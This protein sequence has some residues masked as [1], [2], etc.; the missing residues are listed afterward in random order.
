MTNPLIH[1]ALSGIDV[2]QNKLNASIHN[3]TNGTTEGYKSIDVIS[4]D[5]G[6]RTQRSAGSPLDQN[7]NSPT[8]IQ[9][10]TGTKVIATERNF[11]A[12]PTKL[13]GDEMHVAISGQGFFQVERAG[14]FAYTRAGRLQ[15]KD[16]LLT[17]ESGL[18]LDPPITIPDNL[19]ELIISGDGTITAKIRGEEDLVE[20]GQLV[21]FNF[22]NPN[23]LKAIGDNLYLETSASGGA[24]EMDAGD[25]MSDVIKHKCL[26]ESNVNSFAELIKIMPI[27]DLIK[28]ISNAIK[29]CEET[30]KYIIEH[31]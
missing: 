1:I 14:G 26:E 29:M 17:N 8:G 31:S 7:N 11:T 13:T 2:L 22:S 25:G 24:M 12:G 20:L 6:Y 30:N 23:G 27:T 10:G 5:S 9:Y 28:A 19:D 3:I 21:L 18:P 4:S 15:K 16:G